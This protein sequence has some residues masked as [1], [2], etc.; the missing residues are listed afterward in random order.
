VQQVVDGKKIMTNTITFSP[1]GTKVALPLL[2]LPFEEQFVLEWAKVH[3]LYRGTLHNCENVRSGF[4]DILWKLEKPHR[5]YLPLWS[6]Q[7]DIKYGIVVAT[8]TNLE[9]PS[10]AAISKR[11]SEVLWCIWGKLR[12]PHGSDVQRGVQVDK[13]KLESWTT[14]RQWNKESLTLSWYLPNGYQGIKDMP[15]FKDYTCTSSSGDHHSA[16]FLKRQ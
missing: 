15:D 11:V 3:N 9:H 16:I 5:K 10:E 4:N 14:L 7:T 2:V 13:V 12:S 1:K 6:T 8:G